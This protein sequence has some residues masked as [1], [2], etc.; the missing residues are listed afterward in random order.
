ML[1]NMCQ[2]ES[3]KKVIDAQG[4]EV[5]K[6]GRF[7]LD[8]DTPIVAA[9]EMLCDFIGYL[10]QIESTVEAQRKLQEDSKVEPIPEPI[11]EPELV[12][13]EKLQECNSCY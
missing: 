12:A 9:K 6:I 7:L 11:P 10:Q 1:K 13:E 8:N 4:S 5:L 2:L 3:V